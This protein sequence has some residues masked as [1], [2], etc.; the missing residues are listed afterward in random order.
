[1]RLKELCG[2]REDKL[3]EHLKLFQFSR[4]VED[5]ES[6]ISD[7]ELV[8]LSQDIG[9]DFDHVQMLEERFER[10]AEETKNIGSDRLQIGNAIADQLIGGGHGDGVN[11]GE[12]KT[13]VNGSWDDLLE[14]LVTRKEVN[15]L[16]KVTSFL[17]KENA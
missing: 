2:E 17:L 12:Y 9:Q 1:M 7:R 10:Y 15:N 13:R 16:S 4:E 6:W 8:A 3:D 14:L 11:I 5:L